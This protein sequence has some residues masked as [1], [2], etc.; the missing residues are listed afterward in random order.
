MYYVLQPYIIIIFGDIINIYIFT[1]NYKD[2]LWT[3]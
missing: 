3:E 2:G 1:A